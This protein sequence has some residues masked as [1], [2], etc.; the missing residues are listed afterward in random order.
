MLIGI[1]I[2]LLLAAGGLLACRPAPRAGHYA[3]GINGKP[4]PRSQRQFTADASH[5][6]RTPVSVVRAAADV[7]LSREHRDE[8]EYREA[9]AIV[10]ESGAADEPSRRRHAGARPR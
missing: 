10:G 4:L 6:L 5:E 9:L 2:V 1:P 3:A 7:A 8:G